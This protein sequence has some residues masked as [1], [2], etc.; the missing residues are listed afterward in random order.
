MSGVLA[1]Y[2]V[3]THPRDLTVQ[4]PVKDM[5]IG[6][7]RMPCETIEESLEHAFPSRNHS[8]VFLGFG[9]LH[10][11]IPYCLLGGDGWY[12]EGGVQLG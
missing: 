2:V 7:N 5:I 9:L 8:N 12:D 1:G 11:I 3:Y 4:E 10:C 6:Q